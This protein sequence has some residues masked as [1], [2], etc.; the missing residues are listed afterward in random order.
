MN[1]VLVARTGLL[2]SWLSR[3][4]SFGDRSENGEPRSF[5]DRLAKVLHLVAGSFL[6]YYF[7]GSYLTPQGK[8][9]LAIE[10]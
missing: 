7:S 9:I 4:I 5:R 2:D 6:A 3:L 1:V 10:Y 8:D